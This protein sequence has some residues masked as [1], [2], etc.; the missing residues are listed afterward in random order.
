MIITMLCYFEKQ[1]SYVS[2]KL[3]AA[4]AG[5]SL[6]HVSSKLQYI[7]IHLVE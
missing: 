1:Y 2:R 4:L 3:K 7:Y 6:R 5:Q